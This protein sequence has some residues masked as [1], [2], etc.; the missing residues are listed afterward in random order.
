LIPPP[1]GV[2]ITSMT[3]TAA[4]PPEA[5]RLALSQADRDN[6]VRYDAEAGAA[7]GHVESFFLKA[8]DP[9][10]PRAF[11][12]KFTVYAPLGAKERAAAEV[13]AIAFDGETKKHVA[14]KES[15]PVE[16]ATL[17]RGRP[18]LAFGR[19]TFEPGRTRGEV[20]SDGHAIAWDLAFTTDKPP[21]HHFPAEWLY[22]APVPKS[23][24]LTPH[25]D[26]LF[27]GHVTVDGRR[28][29]VRGWAGAQGHNWGR[30]HAHRY[31]WAHCNAFAGAK[32]TYFEG[33]SSK[34]KL[35]PVKTPWLSI[36]YLRHEGRIHDFSGVRHWWNRTADVTYTSWSFEASDDEVRLRGR[37]ETTPADM[38]GLYYRDPDGQVVH[39]LNSKIARAR[40][41]IA[42]ADAG[43][44]A[45]PYAVL[46]SAH[47]CALEV[48]VRESDHPVKM[49]V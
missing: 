25:P 23:K 4:P 16:R 43:A 36:L 19:S 39:C 37:I 48:A 24:I 15:I 6:L 28:I 45:T 40:I 26:S 17:G 3:E 42:R 12:I 27:E 14:V 20:E 29:D 47:G 49:H 1:I 21:L 22:T 34:V 10:G 18:H 2:S 31:A 44:G 46:E 13:W 8:N 9:S 7:S 32:D 30:E 41:E 11:W 5:P 35:G 38:V 33:L